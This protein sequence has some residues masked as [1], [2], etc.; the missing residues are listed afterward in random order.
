MLEK[1][2]PSRRPSYAQVP[3]EDCESLNP[4][5]QNESPRSKTIRFSSY[6]IF[7]GFIW[8]TMFALA[9]FILGRVHQ[10]DRA[11][12]C[13]DYV[14][15]PSPLTKDVSISYAPVDFNG[16][17][18][19]ENVF[20]RS[21]SPEVDEA[22]KSLGVDYR[23]AHIPKEHASNFG[24]TKDHVKIKEKYGGGFPAN[25]EGMHH[26]HCLNLVRQALY[27]NVD[28]YR[29][30]GQ[31]A[32]KNKEYVVKV[33]VSHCLDILRQQLM[34]SV[35]IGVLG[36]VW[37]N[38]DEPTAFVDFNTRHKCRNFDA[39]RA[40]AEKHQLPPQDEAPLDFL[41]PPTEDTFIWPEIP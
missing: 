17:F 40:W 7:V 13:L 30:K 27:Y 19:H 10:I 29:E 9:G 24:L 8:M 33:H 34:C 22:W 31:G 20:R 6:D 39:V 2:F 11:D 35:D 15:Q 36:Q 4:S 3:P 25:V 38:K 16:T 18:M 5:P 14:S 28:Y 12:A 1:F 41:E 32:F 26:L 23:A 37:W 21:A